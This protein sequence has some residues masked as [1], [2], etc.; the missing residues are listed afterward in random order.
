MA[1]KGYKKVVVR[2]FNAIVEKTTG[3]Y[4]TSHLIRYKFHV[5]I[6]TIVG[7]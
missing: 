3:V 7:Q 5:Q 1:W 2:A 4:F 6:F